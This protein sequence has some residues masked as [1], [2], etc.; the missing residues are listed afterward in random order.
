MGIVVMSC[1]N[2]EF[3][4]SLLV[5]LADKLKKKISYSN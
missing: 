4:N 2:F 5:C 3:L 1:D